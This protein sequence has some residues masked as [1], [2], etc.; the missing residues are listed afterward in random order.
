MADFANL[1]HGFS[2]AFSFYHVWLIVFGVLLGIL[3]GVLPGLGAPNGVTLL[4][5][6]TFTMEPVS[7]IILL[8]SMY[9]GA[10]FGGSTTSILFNIPGEPSSVATTFDGYPMAKNGRATE[11]LATAFF[12]A[13]LG[14]LTGVLVI[15][16]LA[17]WIADFA[18]RFSSPEFFAIYLL[19]F[20]SFIGLGGG[21]PMKAAVSLLAGLAFAT[22]GM[23]TVSGELR[24]T[25]GFTDLLR[26]ISFLVAVI[27]LFGI[28]ELLLTVQEEMKFKGVSSKIEIRE[29]FKALARLPHYWVTFLRSA[30][31]GVWMGITPG[32]PT[33][34]S[35]MS[36]GLG[37]RFGKYGKNFGKGEPEGVIAPETADHSAG[38]SALLP[39]LALG[40]P[41][42]ATA[43]VM[44]G[45][46]MIWGL[47]PGPLLFVEQPDFV[48]GLIASMY[49]SNIIA[50]IL[51]L[52]TVPLFASI[53]R[54]PFGIIG[55]IIIVVCLIGAYTVANAEFDVLMA[56][57]FGIVGYIFKRLDYP[58]APLVLAMVLGDKAEDAFR[59]SMLYSGGSLSI[60]WSNA[61]VGSIMG[62]AILLLLWPILS[63]GVALLFSRGSAAGT[64]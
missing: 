59:Q 46:L 26:G 18:L 22:V 19:A 43:A 56:V 57:A 44:M 4:L 6:L 9:W 35:F 39:M 51:V 36:Y 23:D 60:F 40:V 54:I 45:G 17:G 11:A 25:F 33:A 16:L 32:G 42:S 20:C 24:L 64:R 10:L 15:T 63:K 2:V 3:V 14:A 12:S 21:D 34:A 41:G 28:G 8:S 52:A 1:M 30:A 7:A 27:G 53:L 62:L 13:G 5:P 61:L 29:I 58:I 48:W 50:V 37:R 55:P 49:M 31:V 47:Q 38:T